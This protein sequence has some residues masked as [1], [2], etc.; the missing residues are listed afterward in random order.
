MF[1]KARFGGEKL[2]FCKT[3]PMNEETCAVGSRVS[4]SIF[5]WMKVVLWTDRASSTLQIIFKFKEIEQY[6]FVV[7]EIISATHFFFSTK[8]CA[9]FFNLLYL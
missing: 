3:C 9:S 6:F 5:A 7:V 8:L 2:G 4:P 1:I